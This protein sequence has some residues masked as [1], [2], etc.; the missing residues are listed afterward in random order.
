[1]E[2]WITTRRLRLRP[3]RVS[4]LDALYCLTAHP[5][6]MRFVGDGSTLDRET[7]ALWIR[8]ANENRGRW[9]FGTHAV[10]S[11]DGDHPIGWAGLIHSESAAAPHV[12]EVIYGLDPPCWGRGF[13][14]ELIG[15]APGF[16]A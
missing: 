16:S 6:V 14:S 4:D 12:A 10:L 11:S 7:T 13:A 15:H 2:Y 8:R 3:W 5:E 9:G 1:M